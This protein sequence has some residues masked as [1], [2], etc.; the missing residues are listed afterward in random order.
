MPG[1]SWAP[2]RG[3][4][5]RPSSDAPSLVR[6]T[7]AAAGAGT[8]AGAALA[9]FEVAIAMA[10]I[11]AP[12]APDA[13]LRM[14]AVGVLVGGTLG[15]LAGLP[16]GVVLSLM[17]KRRPSPR[18]VLPLGLAGLGAAVVDLVCFV[19]LYPDA[20]ALLG[21]F[22]LGAVTA[23]AVIASTG[24]W[25]K[26]AAMLGLGIIVATRPAVDRLLEGHLA[27]RHTIVAYTA[28][29]GRTVTWWWPA[30][31]SRGADG[32][33]WPAPIRSQEPPMASN[34]SILLVTIDAFR[35]DLGG[36]RLAEVLPRTVAR[37]PHA[38]RFDHAHAP[39]PRTTYST[40]SML[41]GV[42]PHRLGFVAATTDTEDQFHRLTDD[43]PIMIDPTKWKLRHRYPL[44]DD[45]PTLAGLLRPLGYR[46]GAVVSDVSL[47]PA[48]GISREFEVVDPSPYAALHG[49]DLGGETSETS[50][51][52]GIAFV[53]ERPADVPFLLWLHYRDP[54][55]P[56]TAYPP[57][58]PDAPAPVRYFSEFRRVDDA[59]QRL[60]GALE[61]EGRLQSTIIV[62]T[63]DHGEEFGDHGG[64]YHGTTLYQELVHVPL[65]IAVPDGSARV[66][67]QPVSL[68][69]LA[70][71]LLDL[72]GGSVPASMDGQSFVGLLA[73]RPWV[74]RPLFAYNTSYTAAGQ[75]QAAI[76]EDGLKL[77]EDEG[78][79]TVEL[80]DLASD[81][82][83]HHN[84]ADDRPDLRERLR[85]L[86]WA[87]GVFDADG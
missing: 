13:L 1:T 49:R 77:V 68:T 74:P 14:T 19:N 26:V 60:L 48:A 70:P 67:E 32:C 36:R 42:F 6:A 87:T 18:W 51:D 84:L 78:K 15:M 21:L 69:D 37:L 39:A 25:R 4:S 71:T 79:G 16:I 34:A 86:L 80:F 55:H 12:L 75:R 61:T 65:L 20:H 23:A 5:R 66:L 50:T 64:S 85:C 31:R 62:I 28:V 3:V 54:H 2:G 45:T 7:I 30:D 53:S 59:L 58:P 9:V 24:R 81:P 43:D 63:G 83:E 38:I 44:G 35:G 11:P 8:L 22:T 10:R 72:V 33:T 41:T 73:G 56:Y 47:L 57:V 17:P 52:A 27:I 40:Y 46:T 82:G 76:I 29:I